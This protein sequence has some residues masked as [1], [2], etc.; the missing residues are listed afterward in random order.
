MHTKGMI[1]YEYTFA[2][3]GFMGEK[4]MPILQ[5]SIGK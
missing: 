3:K 5:S 1:D 4:G 2:W